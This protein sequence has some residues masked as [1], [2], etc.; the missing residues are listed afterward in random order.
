MVQIINSVKPI[1]IS[2]GLQ[3]DT[4]T[5]KVLTNIITGLY[6][7]SINN[8]W[9]VRGID[10]REEQLLKKLNTTAQCN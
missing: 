8:V 1:Y 7:N 9:K 5:N 6:R 4:S 2:F 10:K 3:E